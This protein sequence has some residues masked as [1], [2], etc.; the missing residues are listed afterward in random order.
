MSF[1]AI[2]DLYA[3][4]RTQLYQSNLYPY[5]VDSVLITA[6]LKFFNQNKFSAST[7]LFDENFGHE[8]ESRGTDLLA[9]RT[10]LVKP[11]S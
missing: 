3:I 6:G 2:S 10:V 11:L 4:P 7:T 5:S 1:W 9:S 8:E